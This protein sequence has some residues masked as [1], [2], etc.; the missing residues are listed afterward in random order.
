MSGDKI[1][2]TNEDMSA[3]EDHNVP[4]E[5]LVYQDIPFS[6][7]PSATGDKTVD[8]IEGDSVGTSKQ[9][10]IPDGSSSDV[11]RVGVSVIA[12]T[13]EAEAYL[14]SETNQSGV[15]ESVNE[16]DNA[17][18]SLAAEQVFDMTSEIKG[19][20]TSGLEIVESNE[21][22]SLH[23][24]ESLGQ[25]TMEGIEDSGGSDS[26]G[27][28]SEV[29]QSEC[30]QEIEVNKTGN[31][32]GEEFYEMQ[33][34]ESHLVSD[35]LEINENHDSSEITESHSLDRSEETDKTHAVDDDQELYDRQ[36][37]Y[38]IQEED[39]SQ[40]GDEIQEGEMSQ[41]V[42]EIQ[43]VDEVQEMGEVHEV[44]E[45]Q[46]VDEALE[47]D[48]VQEVN[49]AHAV[50][51]AL[52]V[53]EAQGEVQ[54]IDE[55]QDVDEAQ[56]REEIQ[57]EHEVQ[58]GEE[59][60]EGDEI[61]EGFEI[62]EAGD[63]YEG[64]EVHDDDESQEESEIPEDHM[65]EGASSQSASDSQDKHKNF[66][67]QHCENETNENEEVKQVMEMSKTEVA[68]L[69]MDVDESQDGDESQ[70]A[71]ESL[72]ID[73][74]QE[75]SENLEIDE[76]HQ[77]GSSQE[78]ESEAPKQQTAVEDEMI[79]TSPS[80]P[81]TTDP[82]NSSVHTALEGREA[83]SA[84][85]VSAIDE[86]APSQCQS[87]TS[88]IS[89]DKKSAETFKKN[90]VEGMK[91]ENSK[92]SEIHP[93]N[94]VI[95]N[96]I[97][98]EDGP[99]NCSVGG[100]ER[101]E[102]EDDIT[103]DGEEDVGE[104]DIEDDGEGE[105]FVGDEEDFEDGDDMADEVEVE[106]EDCSDPEM[107]S[108][109]GVT[110]I[111][112]EGMIVVE[113]N[114]SSEAFATD[115]T[116]VSA[117]EENVHSDDQTGSPQKTTRIIIKMP[118]SKSNAN[119]EEA[120]VRVS[121]QDVL[122][123]T[124]SARNSPA[125]EQTSSS[126]L[127]E[128]SDTDRS[129]SKKAVIPSANENEAPVCA[130]EMPVKVDELE[131]PSNVCMT[132]IVETSTNKSITSSSIEKTV[133]REK[134]NRSVSSNV[135]QISGSD[136]N[137]T[138]ES[139]NAVASEKTEASLLL[140]KE[141]HTEPAKEQVESSTGQQ[142]SDPGPQ[143]RSLKNEKL[144]GIE[145]TEQE[146][147]SKVAQ[148]TS[149]SKS[150]KPVEKSS[151]R[152]VVSSKAQAKI[153]KVI[154]GNKSEKVQK[155]PSKEKHT[156]GAKD[157]SKHS[158][159]AQKQKSIRSSTEEKTQGPTRTSKQEM[160][161]KDERSSKAENKKQSESKDV[162]RS[163]QSE[164]QHSSKALP[165]QPVVSSHRTRS[166]STSTK[167]SSVKEKEKKVSRNDEVS[168]K[169]LATSDEPTP[170]K[171][172]SEPKVALRSSRSRKSQTESTATSNS[173]EPVK[174]YRAKPITET[175]PRPRQSERVSKATEKAIAS[176]LISRRSK[177][178]APDNSCS[179]THEKSSDLSS[180][181]QSASQRRSKRK[182]D[183]SPPAS[184]EETPVSK[185]RTTRSGDAQPSEETTP[186]T[187]QAVRSARKSKNLKR[188]GSSPDV[189]PA[190]QP[191][192]EET[193]PKDKDLEEFVANISKMCRI[194]GSKND[195]LLNVFG[196]EGL[197]MQLSEKIHNI[198]P[199]K[200][201]AEEPLPSGV[202]HPCVVTLM[203]CEKLV[204]KC[205]S[206][207]K[208]LRVHFKCPTEI[209]QKDKTTQLE[210]PSSQT[211]EKAVK[212]AA[213]AMVNV[214]EKSKDTALK[215][216]ELPEK[217]KDLTSDPSDVTPSSVLAPDLEETSLKSTEGSV[218]PAEKSTPSQKHGQP[219]RS[220]SRVS[221]KDK[222]FKK[223]KKSSNEPSKP[224]TRSN[225]ETGIAGKSNAARNTETE[226]SPP[227]LEA[228]PPQSVEAANQE[229]LSQ[230][231]I[232]IPQPAKPLPGL[233][234]IPAED[235]SAKRFGN[236]YRARM[237]PG[238][239]EKIERG[240]E[241][242]HG[243]A[244]E[245]EQEEGSCDV[246]PLTGA[247]AEEFHIVD[248]DMNM[249]EVQPG[250]APGAGKSSVESIHVEIPPESAEEET[251]AQQASPK[252][253]V[254]SILVDWSGDEEE[255]VAPAPKGTAVSQARRVNA[256]GSGKD[257]V[258]GRVQRIEALPAPCL[259]AD[260][261]G[262][263]NL[264]QVKSKP[265][266][267]TIKEE[268]FWPEPAPGTSTS[269]TS[270]VPSSDVPWKCFVCGKR[271]KSLP[272]FL[273]HKKLHLNDR[274]LVSCP[275]C[276]E[277]FSNA[278]LLKNHMKALHGD[279]DE[280]DVV[281]QQPR[282]SSRRRGKQQDTVVD[283]DFSPASDGL[284]HCSLCQSAFTS[285]ESLCQHKV[286]HQ[287]T[288]IDVFKCNV[289][290]KVFNRYNEYQHHLATH[291]TGAQNI[292]MFQCG[293]CDMKMAN[294]KEFIDHINSHST[295]QTSFTCDQCEKIFDTKHKLRSHRSTAHKSTAYACHLC[296]KVCQKRITLIEH[297]RKHT[298]DNPF[299]CPVCNKR[300]NRLANYKAH[301]TIH[302]NARRYEC[303]YCGKRFNRQSIQQR[304]IKTHTTEQ[305]R[306]HRCRVC[307][308]T[309]NLATEMFTH[310]RLHTRDEVERATWEDEKQRLALTSFPC[311]VCQIPFNTVEEV[312][313][314][315]PSHTDEERDIAAKLINPKLE[316]DICGKVLNSK[317][318]FNAH[319]SSHIDGKP[320]VCKIC[321]KGYATSTGLNY[322]MLS[323][324]GERP[325]PCT[326]CHKGY[327]NSTDLK[328]HMRQHTGEF[329]YKCNKC[330]K[331]F[332]SAS[333]LQKHGFVHSEVRP[334]KCR[335]CNM[336]FK[337]ETTKHNHERIHTNDRRFK[338]KVCTR[339]FIQKGA[340]DA[341]EKLHFRGGTQVLL[342]VNEGLTAHRYVDNF[343]NSQ[344]ISASTSSKNDL[345]EDFEEEEFEEDDD[346]EDE[347][348][349]YEDEDGVDEEEREEEE[350][351][352]DTDNSHNSVK[353]TLI[354]VPFDE[355]SKSSNGVVG[356][357]SANITPIPVAVSSD[358]I[359][360]IGDSSLHI[361]LL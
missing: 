213:T 359:P 267:V 251:A 161:S 111:I 70:D 290:G 10:P 129:C 324:T 223:G 24:I 99:E 119:E 320:F 326:F 348:I 147:A 346:D 88:S 272:K 342:N 140:A 333:S 23:H 40:E 259:F 328:V 257:N 110:Y 258:N 5:T 100:L 61:Q 89:D 338:C 183:L 16:L 43:E 45:V 149:T 27:K 56:D 178:P 97:L 4:E 197:T 263:E 216:S 107:E 71:E 155:E 114:E 50:D 344:D 93:Q 19:E 159:S 215:S 351:I 117:E 74:S 205:S 174:K 141:T 245:D 177:P 171:S 173:E 167:D 135:S 203:A 98:S 120:E 319:R 288:E 92:L 106:I 180:E 304:H 299:A 153:P 2:I 175:L 296:D 260:D 102:E 332:R 321:S 194:C 254:D 85:G 210:A 235:P 79:D 39:V 133:K 160:S 66:E 256:A 261:E 227:I 8:D 128:V 356:L 315:M 192:T 156:L 87:H 285:I 165:K 281:E 313:T 132:E 37:I 289:C 358:A 350:M 229:P 29:V 341:H 224:T 211:P 209:V 44:N 306:K 115:Q 266:T 96:E 164:V 109:G 195:N 162:T 179:E 331:A 353:T 108:E 242:I 63:V 220:S 199:I 202:C 277:S 144:S 154:D 57:E 300:F 11:S 283:A 336:S 172:N 84:D 286:T 150:N 83:N 276:S 262:V 170:N 64:E 124:K 354:N 357:P 253:V 59:I 18:S 17:Q 163:A 12:S 279:D 265:T 68:D 312:L 82:Q 302:E 309:F 55:I 274:K 77:D 188:K 112:S 81:T 60:Q 185:R 360:S 166:N 152:S 80:D 51:E 243:E 345:F 250:S 244:P 292:N 65:S 91:V 157:I 136:G 21:Q 335:Y 191:H 168:E 301:M 325:Y 134:S 322:H 143:Q 169:K 355:T 101:G 339:T 295:E 207:D 116:V 189:P 238:Q 53:D 1:L 34:A 217:S 20:L 219:T 308:L 145:T 212:G 48:E 123:A 303:P 239:W 198:L 200:I 317:R 337:R 282:V 311:K 94:N 95:S 182:A 330:N 314:H 340:C 343:E 30:H 214:D 294:Q 146:K 33:V 54:E 76:R 234:P 233:V 275:K 208:R 293:K 204:E 49:E 67:A 318:T 280:D 15:L 206:I 291:Q 236:T 58:D 138:E 187:P 225:K 193:S 126:V 139:K 329:P 3:K 347:Y 230:P 222:Q 255:V 228:E 310:R 22:E 6:G 73:E 176:G 104:G 90:D 190:K 248:L 113:E 38:E 32:D 327:K 105:D 130:P 28:S 125:S 269:S 273:E 26:F 221:A 287:K 226:D 122:E 13:A 201:R 52:A 137:K 127:E 9:V 103:E 264:P 218:T 186:S 271:G 252:S 47:V 78:V 181:D 25:H 121:N 69:P 284:Y 14:Y 247:Q 246:K 148:Q 231:P 42:Y 118:P 278:G 305:S 334:F 298:G 151:T 36:V 184:K 46:D 131:K 307:N 361:T 270:E 240:L 62:Y 349:I 323:H 249:E 241:A 237:K 297:L 196:P 352:I 158:H 86:E 75:V 316:C 142:K 232:L 35:S 31:I 7:S 72:K 41:E 268:S